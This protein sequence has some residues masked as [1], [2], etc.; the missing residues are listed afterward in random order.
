M[1]E[2][3]LKQ[4]LAGLGADDNAIINAI[5]ILKDGDVKELPF[6]NLGD[7]T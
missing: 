4:M 3:K 6:Q 5:A 7:F 2:E 1:N